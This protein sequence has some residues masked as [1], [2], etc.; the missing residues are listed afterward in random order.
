MLYG[1]IPADNSDIREG[2]RMKE[3]FIKYSF[4]S[5]NNFPMQKAN[6]QNVLLLLR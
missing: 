3:E 2:H 1:A 6:K 4:I 5:K